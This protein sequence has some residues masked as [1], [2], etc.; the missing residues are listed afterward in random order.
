MTGWQ[1][2][3]S[4]YRL[5]CWVNIS[6]DGILKYFFL[7]FPGKWLCH[8][9]QIVSLG[10]NLHEI[11]KPI[12]YKYHQFVVCPESGK[13]ALVMHRVCSNRTAVGI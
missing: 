1:N 6:T 9:M 5:A 7:V 8:F 10:D 13:T 2:L 12:F 3:F 11:A 4:D